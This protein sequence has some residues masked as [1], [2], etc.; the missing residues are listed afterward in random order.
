MRSILIALVLFA[1]ALTFYSALRFKSVTIENDITDRVTADLA[2]TDAKNVAI[3]VDGRHVTLSGVVYDATAEETYLDTADATYGALGPIDGLTYQADGGYVTAI[4]TDAGISLRGTVPNDAA[5][6]AL[7]AEATAATSGDVDDQLMISGP[8]AAW[9]D[10]ASFGIGQL[11][12]L[13]TGTV[14]A[15][16][17]TL[18]LSGMTDGDADSVNNAVNARDGWQALVSAPTPTDD[19]TQ[20]ITLLNGNVADRDA[21]IAQLATE[22]NGLSAALATVRGNLLNG[23]SDIAA[24]KTDRDSLAVEL[25]DLRANLTTDQSNAADLRAALDT[26]NDGIAERDATIADLNE[27]IASADRRVNGGEALI[28]AL[29]T[30]IEGNKTDAATMTGR[31]TEL[32]TELA[33]RQNTLGS[34]DAEVARLQGEVTNLTDVV[35]ARDADVADLTGVVSARNAAIASLS[36]AVATGNSERAALTDVVASRDATIADLQGQLGEVG[37]LSS[38]VAARDET[39]ADLRQSNADAD[40][41]VAALK[42]DIATRDGT[43]ATM[44]TTVNDTAAQVTVLGTTVDTQAAEIAALQGSV[45]DLNA[46]VATR[47]ATIASLRSNSGST[48]SAADQCAAQASAVMEGSQINFRT[49]T[50]NIDGGSTDLLERLTGIALACVGENLTVEVGGHT[51]NQGSDADNQALSEA[52]AQAV[53]AFMAERGVPTSGLKAVGYGESQ[54]VADNATSAGRAENRRISFDWQAR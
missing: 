12:G 35:A 46:T 32:E 40:T 44:S 48:V 54:P 21:E 14:T 41:M 6:E 26:A 16:A 8:V 13:T 11:A 27:G 5:R 18:A 29:S 7:I 53:L 39:I 19:L 33:N 50:A 28:A 17:G 31:I 15:A 37:D 47:D 30:T 20:Q 10:E 49:A 34:T 38:V 45:S 36:S 23:Q 2:E 3:D 22:R 25:E 9:Q 4:K 42:S 43:I 1:T 24:L 52:R 51:D